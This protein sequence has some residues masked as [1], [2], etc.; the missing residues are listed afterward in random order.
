MRS[1]IVEPRD[2]AVFGDG[3]AVALSNI[4]RSHELP[5]PPTVAGLAR[6]RALWGE[7]GRP[8][9]GRD[10]AAARAEAKQIATRGPFLVEL[11]DAGE[12]AELLVPGPRDAAWTGPDDRRVRRR[13]RPQR[14]PEGAATDLSGLEL[15]GT[16]DPIERDKPIP[17]LRYWRWSELARWLA[18]PAD[19]DVFDAEAM[20]R[21]GLDHLER[22]LRTHVAID[23][24]KQT[25]SD[26]MLFSTEG[27]RFT[28]PGR[29]RLGVL[30]DCARDDLRTGVVTLGGERRLAT[31]R[32]ARSPWSGKPPAI[33]GSLV[34]LVLLT[35]GL[36][37]DGFLPRF[38][39]GARVTACIVPRPEVVS[40][41]DMEHGR[42]K[43]GR[44]VVPAGSV[45][46]V[47]VEGDA[48]AWLRERWLQ[49]IADEE[50]DRR[51]GFGI[52]VGGVA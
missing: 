21:L 51:D 33:E 15:V 19:E 42:P 24:A 34:R 46:W 17:G 52:V 2:P 3:R 39:A 30:F 14:L 43:P 5:F 44:R 25:A 35:P 8:R 20:A 18:R 1:W 45:Y 16:D 49:S 11:D 38:G 13:L 48:T 27:I 10:L 31:L 32:P 7:D 22:E 37:T 12:I 40:G 28:A 9:D 26:G 41:W 47:R 6:T 29:R 50:Q 23:A 4:I 36:F